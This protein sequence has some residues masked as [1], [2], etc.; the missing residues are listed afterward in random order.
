MLFAL[1]HSI[2]TRWTMKYHNSLFTLE[3]TD[4]DAFREYQDG[5]FSTNRTT[6]PDWT[7]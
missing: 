4:P 2:Y 7:L 5:M 1:N 6:K 3:E